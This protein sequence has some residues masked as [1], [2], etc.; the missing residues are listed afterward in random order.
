MKRV[1]D[2]NNIAQ[3]TKKSKKNFGMLK[4]NKWEH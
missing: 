4:F 1:M 3:K 2:K